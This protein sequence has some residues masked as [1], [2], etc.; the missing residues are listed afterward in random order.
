MLLFLTIVPNSLIG[1][2]ETLCGLQPDI[3]ITRRD[4]DLCPL[5]EENSSTLHAT[6]KEANHV[7][8]YF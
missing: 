1:A 8:I 3:P 4:L 6:S 5:W 2:M 7:L